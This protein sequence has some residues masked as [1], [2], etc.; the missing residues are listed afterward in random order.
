M[1]CF[2]ICSQLWATPCQ[3]GGVRRLGCHY[4]FIVILPTERAASG[5]CWLC[6]QCQLMN[7][8]RSP[9]H[10]L[11]ETAVCL[12]CQGQHTRA[13]ALV[14]LRFLSWVWSAC[15]QSQTNFRIP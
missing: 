4:S 6:D 2:G 5:A 7:T 8:V 15:F 3:V 9:G 10:A 13:V 1:R 12:P 11:E 14:L